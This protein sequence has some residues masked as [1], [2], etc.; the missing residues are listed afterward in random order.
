MQNIYGKT[1]K[2]R[3]E[4]NI[5]L[6]DL[7]RWNDLHHTEWRHGVVQNDRHGIY[8]TQTGILIGDI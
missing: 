8:Q 2:I 4:G 5:M 1:G 7:I 6:Y 3:N